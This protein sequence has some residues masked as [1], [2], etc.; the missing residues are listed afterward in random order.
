MPRAEC[1]DSSKLFYNTF[2]TENTFC[3]GYSTGS[4]ICAGF[5]GG[6]FFFSDGKKWRMRGMVSVAPPNPPEFEEY[7]KKCYLRNYIVFTDLQPYLPWI[8]D[9]LKI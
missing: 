6:G 3:A 9:T 1:H 4:A 2:L 5:G 8:S 7:N